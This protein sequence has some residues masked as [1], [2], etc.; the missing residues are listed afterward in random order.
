VRNPRR[1]RNISAVVTL[2]GFA[3]LGGVLALCNYLP[4]STEMTAVKVIAIFVA[5]VGS[6]VGM[7]G[8]GSMLDAFVQTRR[9]ERFIKGEDEIG[10]WTVD[11]AGWGAFFDFNAAMSKYDDESHR[12]VSANPSETGVE[13]VFSREAFMVGG[14]FHSLPRSGFVKISCPDWVDVSG[15]AAEWLAGVLEFPCMAMTPR[16]FTRWTLRVPVAVGA[17]EQARAVY[18]HFVARFPRVVRSPQ[19]LRIRRNIALAA[20]TAS[21]PVCG[22]A[23]S[24]ANRNGDFHIEKPESLMLLIVCAAS[25]CVAILSAAIAVEAHWALRKDQLDVPDLPQ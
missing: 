4:P 14:D 9:Y 21:A 22:A 11:P 15:P 18:E 13:V 6:T 5:C 10:R 17:E 3:W 7:L 1:I 12:A 8:A 19:S 25:I 20:I 16:A 2:A 24:F 23:M